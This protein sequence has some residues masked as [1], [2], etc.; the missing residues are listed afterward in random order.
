VARA[1][2]LTDLV[3]LVRAYGL[4]SGTCDNYRAIAGQVSREWLQQEVEQYVPLSSLPN[5]FF[6]TMRG[7]DI[8]AAELFPNDDIDPESLDV[9]AID[10][11]TVGKNCRI[12]SNRLPKLE[13]T[14]HVSI[15]AANM[16]LG[17]RL[18]GD[19]GKG[20]PAITH[21][22]IIA[23]MLQETLGKAH[24]YSALASDDI[25][26]VDDTYIFTWFGDNVASLVRQLDE[27]AEKFENA[28]A[29]GAPLPDPPNPA[30]ASATAALMASRL[31]LTARAAGD[32]V[33]YFLDEERL[34]S[35][36]R[37]RFMRG[38]V[39]FTRG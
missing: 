36:S 6:H 25:E 5:A 21:D 13:T 33:I 8:L 12:N 15:L 34:L 35:A 31:R 24:R 1:Y 16:L 32:Q 9:E 10:V 7:R 14:I 30:I 19:H 26:I 4:L 38:S 22:L 23:T 37:L 29:A 18:Y 20:V 39:P 11:A 3:K 2:P 17:V 27:F 28:F